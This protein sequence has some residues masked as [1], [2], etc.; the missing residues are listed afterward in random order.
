MRSGSRKLDALCIAEGSVLHSEGELM[1]AVVVAHT[2][3]E[4]GHVE[5]EIQ[6]RVRLIGQK[7]EE[8]SA[9]HD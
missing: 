6:G 4:D 8:H 5:D 9:A 1:S 7:V 2:I 3:A